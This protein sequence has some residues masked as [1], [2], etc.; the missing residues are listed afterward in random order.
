MLPKHYESWLLGGGPDDD[1]LAES[2]SEKQTRTDVEA[3]LYEL[4]RV[5]T[6][7][8]YFERVYALIV[9]WAESRR[10]ARFEALPSQI[11][12]RLLA[13]VP[14]ITHNLIIGECLE[15]H[16]DDTR[17]FAETF[18]NVGREIMRRAKLIWSADEA[19][20]QTWLDVL[21]TA[22][23]RNGAIDNRPTQLGFAFSILKHA[24]LPSYAHKGYTIQAIPTLWKGVKYDSKLEAQWA[25]F[26]DYLGIAHE[27]EP[28]TVL[29]ERGAY[30]PDFRV[31]VRGFV[32]KQ[33]G[34]RFELL[35]NGDAPAISVFA[36]VKN[37]SG[38]CDLSKPLEFRRHH[39]ILILEGRPPGRGVKW[40]GY[41]A[42]QVSTAAARARSERFDVYPQ[43]EG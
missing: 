29:L 14:N 26:F 31:L 22:I 30:K 3:H 32:V 39:P 17:R 41:D 6:T 34:D 4:D 13:I 19:R 24:V 12:A 18:S 15:G 10:K 33:T 16:S 25:V 21:A 28:E 23:D 7:R 9:D 2:E 38:R 40:A 1:L 43:L 35:V 37:D 8:S 27:R 20:W 42:V 36:E 11:N 5:K